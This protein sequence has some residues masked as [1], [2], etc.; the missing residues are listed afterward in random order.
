VGCDAVW[1]G[2]YVTDFLE[3][4]AAAIFVVVQEEVTAL[5]MEAAL[6]CNTSVTISQYTQCHIA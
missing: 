5:K 2:E 1:I 4:F 3:A 6:S